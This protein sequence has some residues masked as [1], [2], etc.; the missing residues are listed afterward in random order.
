LEL[1]VVDERGVASVRIRGVLVGVGIGEGAY[2]WEVL[3]D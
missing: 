1:A 3:V 2:I